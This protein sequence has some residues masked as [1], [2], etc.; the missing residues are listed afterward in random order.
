M[1]HEGTTVL[2][3]GIKPQVDTCVNDIS[4]QRHLAGTQV[5]VV[6]PEDAT[7]GGP[8]RATA[9]TVGTTATRIPTVGLAYRRTIAIRNNGASTVFLGESSGVTVA[10]GFPLK[11]DEIFHADATGDVPVYGISDS[12]SVDVRVME[13]S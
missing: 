13:L 5:I 9:M 4:Q 6:N 7:A 3:S 10:T 8:F 11:P 12:S 2:G 1:A